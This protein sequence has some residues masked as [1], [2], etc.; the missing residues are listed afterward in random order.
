MSEEVIYRTFRIRQI[1]FGVTKAKLDQG[2]RT[3]FGDSYQED[4]ISTLVPVDGTY[5][6]ATVSP[7][8]GVPEKF[9]RCKPG[10]RPKSIKI[11]QVGDDLTLDCDFDGMTPLYAAENPQV[12]IIAVTGLAGHAYGSWR[13]PESHKMWLRDFL[14]KDFR[15]A[16][17]DV[18][19]LTYGYNAKLVGSASSSSFRDFAKQFTSA[20]NNARSLPSERE[21]PIIFIGHSIGGL[22]IKQALA[23]AR[24]PDH[25]EEQR[26]M[27]N[28]SAALFFFGVPNK[29][30]NNQNLLSMVKGQKNETLIRDLQEDSPL[31]LGAYENFLR[32]F[33]FDDCRITSFYETEDTKTAVQQPDGTWKRTGPAIRMVS[34]SSATWVSPN[35]KVYDQLP[36]EADHSAMVKFYGPSDEIYR[37]VKSKIQQAV[38][39]APGVIK[40]RLSRLESKPGQAGL[41]TPPASPGSNSPPTS[42]APQAGHISPPPLPAYSPPPQASPVQQYPAP[43]PSPPLSSSPAP[44]VGSGPHPQTP[45]YPS[46]PASSFPA[47]PTGTI[48]NSAPP[49]SAPP[50]SAPEE[51]VNPRPAINPGYARAQMKK[52]VRDGNLDAVL[53]LL[54]NG[55]DPNMFNGR[56]MVFFAAEKGFLAVLKALRSY[57]AS[58]SANAQDPFTPLY[59]ATRNG[60]IETVRYLLQ[61]GQRPQD[62]WKN[63]SA[64]EVAAKGKNTQI[65][66]LLKDWPS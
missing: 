43:L 48:P 30:L 7:E 13:A 9:A 1:P 6:C 25:S 64:L 22:V 46:P 47:P 3:F 39:K 34:T 61:N 66:Q 33:T 40:T 45:S 58:L 62:K 24:P 59:M 5:Q 10:Q 32:G 56:S 60:H 57:G 16:G 49:N 8:E 65:Y 53:D 36:I 31:L 21:R 38:E 2:L 15:N 14:P 23:D 18:R 11:P 27:F 63:K 52:D 26:R 37:T 12:D 41:A 35:E 51:F 17:L 19:V 50:N 44:P 42:N 54:K 28:S 4:F 55:A 29:G 20:V